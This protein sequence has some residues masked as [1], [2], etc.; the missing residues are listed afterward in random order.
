MMKLLFVVCAVA[1][2]RGAAAVNDKCENDKTKGACDCDCHVNSKGASCPHGW[3]T[4]TGHTTT[5]SSCMEDRPEGGFHEGE[6]CCKANYKG[7]S[8]ADF[9][10]VGPARSR[11]AR[12]AHTR[13]TA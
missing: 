4:I 6:V 5:D 3:G 1:L 8:I 9:H 13:T 7:G 11:A 12:L 2:L 10:K